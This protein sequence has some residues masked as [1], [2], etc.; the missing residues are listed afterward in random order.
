MV[1][2]STPKSTQPIECGTKPVQMGSSSLLGGGD[3][4]RCGQLDELL[5]SLYRG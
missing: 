4:E 1:M 3:L 2:H 5:K